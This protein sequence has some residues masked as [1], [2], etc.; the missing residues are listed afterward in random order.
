M[1]DSSCIPGTRCSSSERTTT[2]ESSYF[3]KHRYTST[4]SVALRGERRTRCSSSDRPS[5]EQGSTR[6]GHVTVGDGDRKDS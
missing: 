3:Q 5:C 2:P 4:W 1:A 6:N